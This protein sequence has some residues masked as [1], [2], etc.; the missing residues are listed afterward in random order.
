M[1][2]RTHSKAPIVL[3]QQAHACLLLQSEHVLHQELVGVV[4]GQENTLDHS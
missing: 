4:P 1:L 3:P 2:E